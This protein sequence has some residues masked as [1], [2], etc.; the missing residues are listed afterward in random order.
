MYEFFGYRAD[1]VIPV[2]PGAQ[3]IARTTYDG[4]AGALPERKNRHADGRQQHELL[5]NR[6]ELISATTCN[7]DALTVASWK[8]VDDP[9]NHV[10][11]S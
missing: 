1:L 9:K 8:R 2:V 11:A 6:A 3:R 5:G 4:P 7:N 10:F